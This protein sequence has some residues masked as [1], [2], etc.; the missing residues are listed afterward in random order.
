MTKRYGFYSAAAVKSGSSTSFWAKPDGSD[1]EV[2]YVSEDPKGDNYSWDDKESLG[3]VT[4]CVRAGKRHRF[5]SEV[6]GPVHIRRSLPSKA[7][8]TRGESDDW[9]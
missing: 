2:S 6:E 5:P 1:V 8:V 7:G 3:E 9:P 4:K